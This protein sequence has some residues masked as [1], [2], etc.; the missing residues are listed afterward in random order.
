MP[1]L[2]PNLVPP[3]GFHFYQGDVRLESH[4]E[5]SIIQLISTYR[6]ENRLPQGNPEV[7]YK[8][9][10]CG[11]F[12]ASCY[13]EIFYHQTPPIPQDKRF[14]LMDDVRDWSNQIT[15]S[16]T[17]INLVTD[18]EAERRAQICQ[19]CPRNFTWHTKSCA[20]CIQSIES[21]CFSIRQGRNTYT[22]SNL[23]GCL[24]LRQDNRTAVFLDKSN[25]GSIDSLPEH[26]WVK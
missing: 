20:P 18:N 21:V 5:D 22:S 17:P 26:C 16:Q 1:R 25:L 2:I 4:S 6:A 11:Q 15:L 19:R 7:E 3:N 13:P 23:G 14:E 24:S 8:E 9:Y 10:V 12:P